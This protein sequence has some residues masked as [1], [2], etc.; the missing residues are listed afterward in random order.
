[1]TSVRRTDAWAAKHPHSPLSVAFTPEHL[2]TRT[3]KHAIDQAPE[4]RPHEHSM[5]QAPEHAN[6]RTHEHTNTRTH[7]RTNTRTHKHT[8]TRIIAQNAQTTF[9]QKCVKL[10]VHPSS[11]RHQTILGCANVAG[12]LRDYLGWCVRRDLP[13]LHHAAGAVP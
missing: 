11:Q 1:M 10:H 12:L 2:N 7:E 13:G 6:T 9:L 8:N 4:H 5:N 3:L